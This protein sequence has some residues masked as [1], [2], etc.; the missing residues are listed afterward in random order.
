LNYPASLIAVEKKILVGTM[1]KRF[2]VVV[3]NREHK[4][5][6]LA[7]CKSPEV[8]ITEAALHQ[9]LNYQRT[10]QCQYWLL[11]NGHQTYCANACSADQIRW[12]TEL[13]AY[14]P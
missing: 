6:L 9:L 11:T 1:A 5:W 13:P 4:P 10:I 3:Y 14:E 12:L 2:D 8:T 7:E